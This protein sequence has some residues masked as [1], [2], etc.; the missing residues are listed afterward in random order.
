MKKLQLQSNAAKRALKKSFK[1]DAQYKPKVISLFSGC[2]GMDLGFKWEGYDILWANDNFHQACET[3]KLNFGDHIV[4]ADIEKIDFSKV[5]DCDVIL[6]GFPCQDFSMIWKRGGITTERGNLYKYFVKAVDEKAPKVFVAENVK[7]LMTANNGAAIRQI[8]E[9]FSKCAG[10]GYKIYAN[11]YNFAHYGAP[12]F[13]ERV[14]I[15]GIRNDV[16]FEYVKPAPTHTPDNYYTA[17]EALRGADKVPANNEHQNIMDKTRK[18]LSLIPEGGNFASV[19]KSSPLYVKGM[20]SHVYRRLHQKKPSTTIIAGG[21]GGTWGYHFKEPRPLTNRERARLFGYPDDFVFL[22]T[23]T[24]VRKQIG[25]SVPPIAIKVIARE[26]KKAFAD[27]NG[28]R[29]TSKKV[30]QI[31]I[32]LSVGDE[33]Q[34]SYILK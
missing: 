3:Y 8:I 12:Q 14:L 26:L 23:I 10:V 22:G 27:R 33:K 31:K 20:I 11:V 1:K 19:P 25:N 16:D 21:G 15:I 17:G 24:Q 5:P 4:E 2:G 29:K 9:D 30:E 7:G 13:R 32:P 28:K 6:G 18:L 34:R